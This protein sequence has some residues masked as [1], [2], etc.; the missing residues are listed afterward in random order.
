VNFTL[1]GKPLDLHIQ[2]TV[3]P[4]HEATWDRVQVALI[5][6]TD[7][8][9]AEERTRYL[10]QHDVLTE[11]KN[12]AF[13]QDQTAHLNSRGPFP[14]GVIGVDVNGLKR[15]N[16]RLG[17]SAG[18]ALLRRAARALTSAIGASGDVARMGGDEF[19]CLLPGCDEETLRKLC[20]AI[21]NAVDAQN[22]QP[23]EPTLSVSVGYA[24]CERTGELDDALRRAD[25][26]MYSAKRAH[27]QS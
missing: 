11:V 18:D 17:H 9:R 23:N 16:D 8:K 22:E 13:Y 25:A 26:A 7:R 15:V 5:N 3:L 12:R 1:S 4:G 21:E 10:V 6:I 19:A 27:Y 14:V 24:V 20:A 2:W